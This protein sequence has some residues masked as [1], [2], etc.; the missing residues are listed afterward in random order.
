[1]SVKSQKQKPPLKIQRIEGD[2]AHPSSTYTVIRN[3][4][5]RKNIP[6]YFVVAQTQIKD[7]VFKCSNVPKYL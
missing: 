6:V 4:N 2:F 5:P 3:S 1:M 7:I